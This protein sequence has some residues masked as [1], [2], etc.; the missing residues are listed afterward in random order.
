[1]DGGEYLPAKE[2]NALK[3]LA[4]F[5][6]TGARNGEWEDKSGLSHGSFDRARKAL[7]NL[8]YVD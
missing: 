6:I 5:G 1:M 8:G 7:L 4:T 3:T 2:Y